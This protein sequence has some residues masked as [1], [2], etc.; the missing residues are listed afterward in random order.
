MDIIKLCLERGASKAEEIPVSK[1]TLMP[2][3]RELCEQNKCGRFGR[4][5]T[6][7]PYVGD[8]NALIESLKTYKSA[9]IWQNIY[10]LEDSFDF[11][12]MM[13]AQAKHNTQTFEIADQIYGYY[14]R[15]NVLVLA[16]GGCTLCDVCAVKTNEPCRHPN[17][18]LSSLEAYGIH[19]A[20]IEEVSGLKYINGKDTVTYF[21]GVFVL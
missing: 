15:A 1:L 20:K 21:S 2:E 7:P 17:E 14:G 8:V 4:N 3:L 6:C 9:I 19:V 13:E 12:G 18:A 11:E 10:A 5:Y 16:A